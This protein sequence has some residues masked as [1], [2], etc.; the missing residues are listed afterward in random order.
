M[1]H[2]SVEVMLRLRTV[3]LGRKEVYDGFCTTGAA[4][5]STPHVAATALLHKINVPVV[6]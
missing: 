1:F 5:I 4:I 3:A 2:R 6:V